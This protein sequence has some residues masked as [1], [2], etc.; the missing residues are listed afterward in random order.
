MADGFNNARAMRVQE[1]MNDYRNIQNYIAQI[2]ANPSAEEYHEEGYVVLRQCVAQAQGLLAQPFQQDS[3]GKES[4]EAVQLHLRRI[5]VDASMRRFRAQN[6]YLRATAVLRWI[7]ARNSIL[8]GQRP[9]A[10]HAP[11]LQQ[12]R[13]QLR[14]E[15]AAITDAR[16]DAALR[17]AD[18]AVGKWLEEDPPLASIQRMLSAGGC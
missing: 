1:I 4:E 16:V 18:M 2:R 7:N 14:V 3:G 8:Q 17:Q 15:L 5:I 11:A 12:I 10:G 9:H 13:D 6:I